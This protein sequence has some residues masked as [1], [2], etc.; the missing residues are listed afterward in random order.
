M[1]GGFYE[2]EVEVVS[3]PSPPKKESKPTGADS[4]IVKQECEKEDTSAP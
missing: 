2:N 1:G 4:S 3:Y